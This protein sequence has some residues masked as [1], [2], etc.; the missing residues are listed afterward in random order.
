MNPP[1]LI[2]PPFLGSPFFGLPIPRNGGKFSPAMTSCVLFN[3][4]VFQHGE[5]LFW[6]HDNDCQVLC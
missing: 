3:C 2:Q 1:F 6:R 4:A 5:K